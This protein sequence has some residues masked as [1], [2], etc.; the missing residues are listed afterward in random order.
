MYLYK[1]WMCKVPPLIIHPNPCCK[2]FLSLSSGTSVHWGMRRMNWLFTS[3]WRN[4]SRG[5]MGFMCFDGVLR[6]LKNP[7]GDQRSLKCCLQIDYL[8]RRQSRHNQS[9]QLLEGGPAHPRSHET[10]SLLPGPAGQL[11]FMQWSIPSSPG[12]WCPHA[13]QPTF[14]LLFLRS[15]QQNH[16]P[17]PHCTWL[18][19]SRRQCW[20]ETLPA[21]CLCL[22][23]R[24]LLGP[25]FLFLPDG[26]GYRIFLQALAMGNALSLM[27]PIIHFS[28][29]FCREGWVWG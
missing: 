24:N 1:T 28:S 26:R 8:L 10:P 18:A 23:Y 19:R 13:T 5:L 2:V 20:V 11:C 9:V 16:L 29:G 6:P 25:M 27:G 12:A 7:Q 21:K 14:Q 15:L 4:S 17:S 3:S 22:P